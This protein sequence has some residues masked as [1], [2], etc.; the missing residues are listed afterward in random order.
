[1]MG[2]GWKIGSFLVLCFFL[3]GRGVLAESL[4]DFESDY[5]QAEGEEWVDEDGYGY[6][7]EE[8]ETYEE[9]TE[10]PYAPYTEEGAAPLPS[11]FT[12]QEEG[13]LGFSAE[14]APTP[15]EQMDDAGGVNNTPE[16]GT[17]SGFTS[18]PAS[19]WEDAGGWSQ[20]L[21]ELKEI[22]QLSQPEEEDLLASPEV[23]EAGKGLRRA[24][25]GREEKYTAILTFPESI[26]SYAKEHQRDFYTTIL[27]LALE[28]TGRG[29]EGDYLTYHFYS[30]QGDVSLYTQ[31]G[32]LTMIIEYSLT[33]YDNGE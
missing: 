1:M 30:C 26:L 27:S 11:A 8:Y 12:P 10:Q 14:V 13:N 19:P 25:T 3:L 18:A 22:R 2:K 6:E 31:E 9:Y 7:G 28:E 33:Y 15:V 29:K 16:D 23:L 24:M 21:E 32:E 5:S 17:S 20:F 4:F